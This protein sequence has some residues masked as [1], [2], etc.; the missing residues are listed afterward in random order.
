MIRRFQKT[1]LRRIKSNEFSEIEKV[2]F[3]FADDDFCKHTLVGEKSDVFAIICFKRYWNN[4]WMAF[5]LISEDMPVIYAREL[6]N[7]I[8]NAMIDLRAERI[9]TDSVDCPELNRWHKFLGFTLEGTRKK[10]IFNQDY[11]MWCKM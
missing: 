1:D 7:F 6:K 3:V 9:Q 2:D 5:F 11:N 4:N 8:N 10:M